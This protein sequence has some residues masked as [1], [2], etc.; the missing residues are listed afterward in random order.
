VDPALIAHHFGSKDG[1]WRAVIEQIGGQSD[2]VVLETRKLSQSAL[3]PIERVRRAVE[4]FVDRVFDDPD[5]GL[6]F[7]TSATEEGDRLR[8]LVDFLVRPIRDAWRPLIKDYLTL[9]RSKGG[10]PD[11]LFFVLAYGITK[12]VSYRHVLEAFSTLPSDMGRFKKEVLR[13][14]LNLLKDS[15]S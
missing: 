1:L 3:S 13:T 7:A 4:L 8:I 14:T 11:V 6:F 5:I 12:T 9:S 15:D 10:D 2:T